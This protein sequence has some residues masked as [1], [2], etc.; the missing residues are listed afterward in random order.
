MVKKVIKIFIL[1]TIILMLLIIAI[2]LIY[3]ARINETDN[4]QTA[5]NAKKQVKYSS[6]NILDKNLTKAE[7]EEVVRGI[8]FIGDKT[9]NSLISSAYFVNFDRQENKLNFYNFPG[10]MIFETSNET[11]NDISASLVDIPQVLRLS[12]LYKYSRNKKGL[13]AGMLMFEDYMELGISH[14]LFL[15]AEDAERLF[16]FNNERES[17][18][19]Q[20]FV[21]LAVNGSDEAISDFVKSVYN[22]KYTDIKKKTY[23]NFIKSLKQ[24]KNENITFRTIKGEKFDNGVIVK[25]EDVFGDKLSNEGEK[26]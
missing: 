12:H 2:L 23:I 6:T 17:V 18:F 5:L 8:I 9:D 21:N 4:S 13:K 20:D 3:I 19:L 11:Y 1:T 26:K 24:I 22:D 16:Y 7:N 14:Y 10:D 25:K 15:R